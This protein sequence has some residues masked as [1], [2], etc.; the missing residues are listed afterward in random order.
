MCGVYA[1]RYSD[2]NIGGFNLPAP[3][4]EARKRRQ[5]HSPWH[6]PETLVRYGLPT[7]RAIERKP[8]AYH[9]HANS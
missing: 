1:G 2:K 6:I 9:R 4:Y 3:S 8:L 5:A 7:S